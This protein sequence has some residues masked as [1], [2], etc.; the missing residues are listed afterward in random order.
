MKEQLK[1][2]WFKVV[3]VIILMAIAVIYYQNQQVQIQLKKEKQ[4]NDYRIKRAEFLLEAEKEE[5]IKEEKREEK[6]KADFK[7][8]SLN[9]CL[10]DAQQ[11]YLDFWE[12]ECEILEKGS[13]CLLPEYNANR[14]DEF[15]KE[16][17]SECFKQYN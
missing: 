8:L 14:A 6:I 5:R 3:V 16:L 1:R 11:S 9:A 4:Q 12:S 2:N 7:E 15:K 17:K 10:A 13:N